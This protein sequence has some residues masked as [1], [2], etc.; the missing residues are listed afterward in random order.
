MAWHI[1]HGGTST[2]ISFNC[3]VSG[4][5]YAYS[6]MYARNAGAENKSIIPHIWHGFCI[7]S[8]ML[9][10]PAHLATIVT[11]IVTIWRILSLVTILGIGAVG[12]TLILFIH[13]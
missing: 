7:S 5:I 11:I 12:H 1:L 4:M 9:S 10:T 8:G 3:R 6:R 13:Q 2:D